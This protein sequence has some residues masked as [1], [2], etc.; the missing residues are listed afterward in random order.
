PARRLIDAG[1]KV[2]LSSD[3]PTALWEPLKILRLAVDRRTEEGLVIRPD[4]AMT[5][6]EAIRAATVGAAEAA[7]VGDDKGRI[8]PGRQAE[9]VRRA[10]EF[11]LEG[12]PKESI[13]GRFDIRDIGRYFPEFDGD[14]L[15]P[16]G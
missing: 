5:R 3:G 9:L 16:K 6:Q 15:R 4:Q 13:L 12:E 14:V 10:F 11:L 8:E 1:V 7:G 2:S